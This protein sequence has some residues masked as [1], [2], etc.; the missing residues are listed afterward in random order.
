MLKI[1]NSTK[2]SKLDTNDYINIQ[3]ALKYT[4]NDMRCNFFKENFLNTLFKVIEMEG[5]KANVL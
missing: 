5:E 1:E 4:A 3:T 2:N